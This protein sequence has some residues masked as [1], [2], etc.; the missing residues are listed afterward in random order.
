MGWGHQ[1]PAEGHAAHG[2]GGVPHC[3]RCS[4]PLEPEDLRCAVCALPVPARETSA[5]KSIAKILRCEGCGAC[6][7]TS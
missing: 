3:T 1:P 5:S 4:T 7:R 6:T 2:G